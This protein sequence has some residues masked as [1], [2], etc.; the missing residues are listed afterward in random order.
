MKK[1]DQNKEAW[2]QKKKTKKPTET[3]MPEPNFGRIGTLLR[4]AH[5]K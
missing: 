2:R 4:V 1:R 3:V 5:S